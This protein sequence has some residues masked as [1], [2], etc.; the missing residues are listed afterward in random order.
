MICGGMAMYVLIPGE[1]NRPVLSHSSPPKT[2]FRSG[3]IPTQ[4]NIIVRVRLETRITTLTNEL[5]Y[6]QSSYCEKYFFAPVLAKP[7][8]LVC[9]ILVPKTKPS[10]LDP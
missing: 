6:K 9:F 1:R 2:M 5:A 3:Y 4:Q 10:P 8:L 7:L